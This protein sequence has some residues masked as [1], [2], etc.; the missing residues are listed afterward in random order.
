MRVRLTLDVSEHERFVVAKY[1][2]PASEAGSVDRYRLRATRK[3]VQ[4]FV[5]A[6]LAKAIKDQTNDLPARSRSAARK[7]A[8][9][10]PPTETLAPPKEEQ[11]SLRW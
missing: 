6:A 8:E 5:L 1:F 10:R 2:A 7:L 3:Q 4:R 9:G 11:R